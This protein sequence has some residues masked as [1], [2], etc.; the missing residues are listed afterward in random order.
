[1]D[2]LDF[3]ILDIVQRD[4]RLPAEKI[5][6]RVGLSPSAVQRRLKRL[7]DERVIE[8]DVAI[9]SPEAAGRGLTAIVEVTLQQERPLSAPMNEFKRMMLD[10]PEVMQCYHVTG[11]AD[12]I[13]VVTAKD[14]QEY[15]AL[16]RR[17]F[18]DNANVRRFRTS[19]VV[20]RVKARMTVPLAG[21][22]S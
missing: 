3:K 8:A 16:T 13:V 11:E 14:M 7:R 15:E 18:V 4:N 2:T 17:F 22:G 21:E 9:V 1:M 10:A 20:S 19:V 5:A 6:E 12:F